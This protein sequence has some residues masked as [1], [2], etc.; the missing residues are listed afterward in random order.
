MSTEDAAKDVGSSAYCGSTPPSPPAAEEEE[1]EEED[2]S[3]LMVQRILQHFE[4]T[5]K[6]LETSVHFEPY[7]FVI[8]LQ[9][10]LTLGPGRL[11]SLQEEEQQEFRSVLQA[12]GGRD[13]FSTP[14][15]AANGRDGGRSASSKA[16]AMPVRL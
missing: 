9:Q 4:I 12:R 13:M 1:E 3:L 7:S 15:A 11:P 6:R 2:S 8:T 10:G 16:E 14:N 5:V